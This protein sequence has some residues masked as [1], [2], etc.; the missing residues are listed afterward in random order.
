MG[1]QRNFRPGQGDIA[2]VRRAQRSLALAGEYRQLS[3][4]LGRDSFQ[5][6]AGTL[7]EKYLP[8]SVAKDLVLADLAHEIYLHWLLLAPIAG[9]AQGYWRPWWSPGAVLSWARVHVH[10]YR[11]TYLGRIRLDWD[12]AE[13]DTGAQSFR[14]LDEHFLASLANILPQ[15]HVQTLRG[16]L[17]R[18][19]LGGLVWRSQAGQALEWARASRSGLMWWENEILFLARK[20]FEIGAIAW[21]DLRD[22]AADILEWQVRVRDEKLTAVMRPEALSRLKS[23]ITRTLESDGQPHFKMNQ[24]NAAI[25]GF[26]H[27]GKY[28]FDARRQAIELE[29]WIWRRVKRGII[30]VQPNLKSS[31]FN[32]KNAKWDTA[33]RYGRVSYLLDR[34]VTDDQWLQIWNPRR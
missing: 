1:I 20:P 17:A 27:W 34:G 8:R 14:I 7:T 21:V 15:T 22:R 23:S 11:K 10:R 19:A 4:I 2:L 18:Y 24:I 6:V 25:A 29:P 26:H 33:L 28:A 9:Q 5:A 12:T 30:Q 31:Y 13:L 3:Q 32:L 16:Q